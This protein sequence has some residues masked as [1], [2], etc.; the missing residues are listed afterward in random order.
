M[1]SLGRALAAFLLA[2]LVASP[3]KGK[4][5]VYYPPPHTMVEDSTI[6]VEGMVSDREL[7]EFE[8]IVNGEETYSVPVRDFLFSVEVD[9]VPGVNGISF[10]EE[11]VNVFSAAGSEGEN[12]DYRRMYGHMG[13]YDGCAECHELS[14]TGK[15]S[16]ERSAEEV[17]E[18]C[19]ADLM[20]STE[21]MELKSVHA[22]VEAGNCLTC[23]TAHLS[24]K[25][26]LPAKEV[27]GCKVCHLETNDRMEK[28]RYVHGPMHL[29]DC[30][31][32]HT[33][34]S[35]TQQAL[36]NDSLLTICPQ[37]HFDVAVEEDTPPELT[38]H[39]LIPQGFCSRCHFPTPPTTPR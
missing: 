12:E 10:G 23:H 34:H 20:R 33:V 24:E 38:P 39:V 1:P 5:Q 14:A 9:L 37:C 7:Y 8:L 26:G 35:S 13:L 36:L 4:I 19:H 18:W 11:S 22:P 29:G 30:R 6:V 28:E 17:C 16:F 32:C 31:L 25:P 3:A 2:L 21:G 27:P 15:L